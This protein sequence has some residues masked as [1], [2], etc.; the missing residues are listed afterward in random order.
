RACNSNNCPVGIATQRPEL[1]ERLPVDDAATRLHRFLEATV[2]M[3]GVLARAC[4]HTHLR[5]FCTDDL[6]TFD[7]DMAHLTGITYG[8]VDR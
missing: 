1:R 8:G 7:R 5:Q 3:M 2:E 4:G 6:T